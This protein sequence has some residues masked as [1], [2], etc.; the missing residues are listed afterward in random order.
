MFVVVSLGPFLGTKNGPF[1]AMP[2]IDTEGQVRIHGD[3]G[4]LRNHEESTSK[5]IVFWSVRLTGMKAIKVI[6]LK[7]VLCCYSSAPLAL[8]ESV[9]LGAP[10]IARNKD[11]IFHPLHLDFDRPTSPPRGHL[12]FVLAGTGF[13]NV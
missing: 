6:Y 12:R 3:R 2:C 9:I 10:E 1:I 5:L 7:T 13:T 11:A 4:A 8:L